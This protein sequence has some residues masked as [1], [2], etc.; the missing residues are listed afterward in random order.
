MERMP[1]IGDEDLPYARE[2]IAAI[3]PVSPFDTSL[4]VPEPTVSYPSNWEVATVVMDPIEYPS[5]L[6]WYSAP[7]I[8]PIQSPTYVFSKD[9]NTAVYPV[10]LQPAYTY[11][12]PIESPP[13]SP[14]PIYVR[15]ID[16]MPDPL[17]YEQKY[18]IES[19][20][21]NPGPYDEPIPIV[22]VPIVTPVPVV[23]V[24]VPV[25]TP[26]PIV[27]VNVGTQTPTTQQAVDDGETAMILG[28][29]WYYVAGAAAVGLL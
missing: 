26:P 18:P 21:W 19:P 23:P 24:D 6:P 15:G 4:A 20:P 11:Q 22:D 28:Y 16:M 9:E 27:T 10:E 29:P 2:L 1:E 5:E 13:Y 8:E 7:V 14:E 17:T 12:Q 3:E 25:T